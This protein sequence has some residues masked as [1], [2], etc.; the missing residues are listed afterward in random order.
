MSGGISIASARP[1]NAWRQRGY[2]DGDSG[3]EKRPPS[4]A[5]DEARA[6]YLA[7]YRNGASRRGA[8]A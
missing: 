2:Q 5:G 6:A 7:G 1:E 4:S 8:N 3:R